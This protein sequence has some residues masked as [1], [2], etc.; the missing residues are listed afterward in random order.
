MK[1]GSERDSECRAEQSRGV[2][3]AEVNTDLMG[4]GGVMKG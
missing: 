3:G 1:E 2:V 4:E